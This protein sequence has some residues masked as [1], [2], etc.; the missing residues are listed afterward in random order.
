MDLITFLV[1]LGLGYGCGRYT[2]TRHFKSIIAR[3]KQLKGLPAIAVRF[4]P[5]TLAPPRTCIVSG[6]VVISIDYFKRFL[7]QLRNLVGGRVRSYET[8]LDRARR[9]AVLRMKEEAVTLGA[10]M[11]FNLKLETASISKGRRKTVG[12]VEVLAYGT[13]IIPV[14]TLTG[15]QATVEIQ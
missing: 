11:I 6:N 7:A 9:E 12:T 14:K 13:A 3:E 1:M 4:P 5:A 2:E 8:L 15:N 10:T